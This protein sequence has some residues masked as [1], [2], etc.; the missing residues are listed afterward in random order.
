[1][2][3]LDKN[4]RSKVY[5]DG[6]FTDL[7]LGKRDRYGI[8]ELGELKAAVGSNFPIASFEFL[9]DVETERGGNEPTP[10]PSCD[11]ITSITFNE[12]ELTSLDFTYS[13]EGISWNDY[14]SDNGFT[15]TGVYNELDS[16]YYYGS[17]DPV[18]FSPWALGKIDSDWY[19]YL[20]YDTDGTNR[21]VYSEASSDNSCGIGTWTVSSSWGITDFVTAV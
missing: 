21:E 7:N 2:S 5:L 15:L 14:V 1:M 10:E 19:L 17:S 3:S 6:V 16:I 12:T 18:S 13:E 20:F 9:A 11:E 4:I 8:N